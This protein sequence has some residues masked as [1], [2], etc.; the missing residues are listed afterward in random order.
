MPIPHLVSGQPLE[1]VTLTVSKG[2]TNALGHLKASEYVRLFD[3]AVPVFFTATGLADQDLRHGE[4]SPFLMDLHA[5][6]LAELG[7]GEAVRIAAHYLERYLVPRIEHTRWW[8]P[9]QT[10]TWAVLA[11]VMF[12]F[13]RTSAYDFVY[14]QF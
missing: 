4:T 2:Q 10:G 12:V 5:C 13:W 14:F 6:Y 9:I 8:L 7:A 1:L 3:D 11:V